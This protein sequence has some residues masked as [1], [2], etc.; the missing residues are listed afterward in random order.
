MGARY[1][2]GAGHDG[3]EFKQLERKALSSQHFGRVTYLGLLVF[4]RSNDGVNKLWVW[5]Y[6]TRLSIGI[7]L[8]LIVLNCKYL[9][10]TGTA[11]V[12][13]NQKLQGI[14]FRNLK[15]SNAQITAWR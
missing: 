8:P 7:T 9:W 1:P 14:E 3:F 11:S 12:T 10:G 6:A 13:L 5:C 15:R 4:M 2:R